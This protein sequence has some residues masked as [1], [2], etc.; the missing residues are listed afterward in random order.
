MIDVLDT[1]MAFKP[2]GTAL[3]TPIND[4]TKLQQAASFA[5]KPVALS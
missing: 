5:Y 3:F 4:W 1:F 2:A